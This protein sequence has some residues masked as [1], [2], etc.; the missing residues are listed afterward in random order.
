MPDLEIGVPQGV[1]D[2][3]HQRIGVGAAMEQHNVHVRPKALLTA[4]VS[5]ERD[6]RCVGAEIGAEFAQS[7]IEPVGERRRYIR[8]TVTGPLFSQRGAEFKKANQRRCNQ[9]KLR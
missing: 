6:G 8:P 4:T 1:Q 5:S 9:L 7:E 3:P 2:G